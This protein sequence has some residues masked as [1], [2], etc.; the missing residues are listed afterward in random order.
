V[1]RGTAHSD[2]TKAAV[3]AALL[4]G[5]SV[6][7]VA[8][9]YSLSRST[10]VAWRNSAG[11][12]STHVEQEKKSELGDLIADYL[13]EVLTTLSVQA[14]AFRD[15]A[16]LGKQPASEVAVLHGVLTDKAIRIL[17]ALDPGD[18]PG[19]AG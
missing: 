2:Q 14:R 7:A 11:L 10:V 12:G 5:Q 13:R 9:S 18:E 6:S 19:T 1:A 16:W 17:G 4:A 15:E 3:L 8:E